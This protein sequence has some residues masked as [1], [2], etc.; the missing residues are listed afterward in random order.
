MGRFGLLFRLPLF[1]PEAERIQVGSTCIALHP[2]VLP[3]D[4]VV[5]QVWKPR[6][7]DTARWAAAQCTAEPYDL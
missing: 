6:D 7:Q 1:V 3:L 2:C 4:E 5:A